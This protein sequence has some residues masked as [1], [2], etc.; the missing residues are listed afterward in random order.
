[1]RAAIKMATKRYI[2]ISLWLAINVSIL[3]WTMTSY[4][5][6]DD[7]Q[8]KYEILM[9]HAV[10][11]LLITFPSGWLLVALVGLIAFLAG[12]DMLGEVDAF[13]VLLVCTA[14]GYWQ[15]FVLLPWLWRQ[16]K[17]RGGA[18]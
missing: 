17:A 6:Q 7:P 9:R 13:L 11:M 14:T 5:A 4:Q 3:A 15:W 10:L 8:L 1:M 2:L 12:I 18:D 16:W